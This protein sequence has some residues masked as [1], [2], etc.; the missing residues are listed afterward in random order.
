MGSLGLG[1][2][3]APLRIPKGGPHEEKG[4][5]FSRQIEH[6]NGV[7]A[8]EAELSWILHPPPLPPSWSWAPGLVTVCTTT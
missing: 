5:P 1:K 2:S 3:K 6:S 7:M 8:G 4:A